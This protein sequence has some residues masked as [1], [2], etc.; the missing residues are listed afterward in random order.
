M[1]TISDLTL[2][3]STTIGCTV[4][5]VVVSVNKNDFTVIWPGGKFIWNRYLHRAEL[6]SIAQ[7][8]A[9]I[10]SESVYYQFMMEHGKC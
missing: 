5:E 10:G 9:A 2:A 8:Y 3:I 4:S 7:F 6:G 1:K